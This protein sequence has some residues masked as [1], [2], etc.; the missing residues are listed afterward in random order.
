MTVAGS[1]PYNGRMTSTP[2]PPSS[3]PASIADVFIAHLAAGDFAQ[4]ATLFEP[5]VVVSALLPDGL[6]E[7]RGPEQVMTAFVGWFGRVDEYELVAAAVDHVGPRLQLQWRARVR[8]GHF[9]EVRHVVEQQVYADPGP[10]G[11]IAHL[12]MLCSGFAPEPS[13]LEALPMRGAWDVGVSP[14]CPAHHL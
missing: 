8:G 7:W 4:L 14:G 9:G 6:H 2:A 13:V 11:R 10:S 3:P 1:S 5:D 12:S